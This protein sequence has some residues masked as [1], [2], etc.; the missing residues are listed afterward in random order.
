[1]SDEAARLQQ[2][3]QQLPLDMRAVML[4]AAL[5]MGGVLGGGGVSLTSSGAVKE[6]VSDVRH[7]L[8]AVRATLSAMTTTLAELQ[9]GDRVRERDAARMDNRIEAL[10][11]R[12]RELERAAPQPRLRSQDGR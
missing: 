7:E 8:T 4:V 5:G 3:Q 9:S 1:M 6:A 12:V 11:K 2:Q 10:E